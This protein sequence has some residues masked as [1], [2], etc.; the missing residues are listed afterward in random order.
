MVADEI[1]LVDRDEI[2]RADIPF[3]KVES[4]YG[5]EKVKCTKVKV[6]NQPSMDI[7][8]IFFSFC[9]M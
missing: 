5:V 8:S 4:N 2:V 3:K 7:L 1:V 6:E 9:N